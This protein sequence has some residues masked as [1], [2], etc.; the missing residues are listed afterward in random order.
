VQVIDDPRYSFGDDLEEAKE[1]DAE[2]YGDQETKPEV[3]AEVYFEEIG[4]P[5]VTQVSQ[6]PIKKNAKTQKPC[7]S[8]H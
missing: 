6:V 8:M 2:E 5:V 7:V 1:E 4:D 3:Q